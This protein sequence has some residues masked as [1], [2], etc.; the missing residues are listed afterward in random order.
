MRKIKTFSDILRTTGIVLLLV[1]LVLTIYAAAT[2][3]APWQD[4][5]NGLRVSGL[6]PNLVDRARFNSAYFSAMAGAR[7]D[8]NQPGSVRTGNAA[9]HFEAFRLRANQ[10]AQELL[11]R[12]AAELE[13]YFDTELDPAP[14][15]TRFEQ[16]DSLKELTE[17]RE[18]F[19]YLDGLSTPA[20]KSGKVLPKLQP[21][22][23]R[24]WFEQR[25]AEWVE[26]HG[27]E[28]G[29]FLEFMQ[30]IER[31]VRDKGNVTDARAFATDLTY[32]AYL[33]ELEATRNQE[34]GEAA[35]TFLD[36]FMDAVEAREG[37]TA[38]SAYLRTE[39]EGM[40]ARYPGGNTPPYAT[41]LTAVRE[42]L[43]D[44]AFDGS[45]S[46]LVNRMRA[47]QP[48][49]AG[50]S[51]DTFVRDFGRAIVADSDS[52][53]A[54]PLSVPAWWLAS[55]TL[56]FWALGIALIILS[57][58]LARVATTAILKRREYKGV[59][60]D[61]DVLLR[62]RNLRQY[63]KS[64]EYVNKAVDD[65]S[66]HIKKGEVFGLV[67][68]SGCGKTTTGRTI[69]NLYDP[70]SGD[71]YFQG[72]RISSTKNGSPVMLYQM[73]KELAQNIEAVKARC[74]EQK[75]QEPGNAPALDEACA[76]E[77]AELNRQHEEAVE[78][79]HAHAF[80][81]EEEK[82]KCVMLYREQRQKEL[83][84]EY[85]QEVA[86]LSGAAREERTRRY[87]IEMDVASRDNIMTKIQMIFQDPIASINPRM[88]VREIIAEGLHIRGVRD[89][90]LINQKVYEML[91]LVGLVPEHADRYPHE[92]SGGQRQ[93]IGIAR[94]IVLEPDLIIADEPISALDVSIQAQI[95]NLLNNLRKKM[96]LTIMFIAHN[97]SV[98]K[99][100]SD[101]I[102]VM[103]FG[104]IVEMAPS[105]ELF[106]HPL[107][108]YTKSLLSAIP[109]P[110]PHY[111][112]M[113]KRI[114]YE[115]V[116]AHDYSVDKPGMHE[117]TPGHFIRANKAE[118]EA[119]RRELNL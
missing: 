25:H 102:A 74:A 10:S 40:G 93:R 80:E 76:K 114:E 50:S 92:F 69:I 94:A 98:V 32:E 46:A 115:P 75:K 73:R 107:H 62:V 16:R 15:V 97:L 71:V 99:Y 84:E 49:Q 88:T 108:P 14:L 29:T 48:A 109:Y 111:E 104:H 106:R 101:R 65:I 55:K 64:G 67:G 45:Y 30:T 79:V 63:F 36:G 21:A 116:L 4:F 78:R 53:K 89:K 7:Q 37:G 90:D 20:L 13:T 68:E 38:L 18:I 26:A 70:T 24:P 113:R 83:T 17:T 61:P 59:Q 100:F 44:A 31:L 6:E 118:L 2:G 103:Y 52:R 54:V 110:D 112:K 5:R 119:Y 117:I 42:A 28:A 56:W 3:N 35:A 91:D 8:E 82:R 60:D 43:D 12:Q 22:S 27:E 39:Y 47:L 1:G 72:L 81:S 9:S 96:G 19:E 87:K 51:F 86:S 66:F 57:Y 105:E 95:I 58:V 33:P 85:E 23:S 11:V 77:I 34:S 41:F